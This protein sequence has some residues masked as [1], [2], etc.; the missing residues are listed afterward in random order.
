MKC[1]YFRWT[2]YIVSTWRYGEE[3]FTSLRNWPNALLHNMQKVVP[4]QTSLFLCISMVWAFFRGVE[5]DMLTHLCSCELNSRPF[6]TE[7]A[8]LA[9]MLLS[10]LSWSVLQCA[11]H[12]NSDPVSSAMIEYIGRTYT[13]GR[14]YWLWQPCWWDRTLAQWP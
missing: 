3:I 8:H 9:S 6:V 5:E 13:V 7:D 14:G 4:L 2:A 1:L 11:R 10:L 12:S